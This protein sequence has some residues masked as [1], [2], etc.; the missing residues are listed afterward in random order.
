MHSC[1]V[2]PSRQMV[3]TAACRP[4]SVSGLRRFSNVVPSS[5]ENASLFAR[6]HGFGDSKEVV[7]ATDNRLIDF[8]HSTLMEHEF[9]A[10]RIIV[11][12][13]MQPGPTIFVD[14][15][16][17]FVKGANAGANKYE[18]L[19]N[20]NKSMLLST[21]EKQTR[22]LSALLSSGLESGLLGTEFWDYIATS[23]NRPRNTPNTPNSSMRSKRRRET[24]VNATSSQSAASL[25]VVRERSLGRNLKQRQVL[26]ALSNV[27]RHEGEPIF[28]S[29]PVTAEQLD[30]VGHARICGLGPYMD[31][32]SDE[33]A[34][35]PLIEMSSV[36]K[37]RG[38]KM[39]K[40]KLRKRRRK[41]KMKA[42]SSIGAPKKKKSWE[43]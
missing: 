5:L 34:L 30:N 29:G 43:K 39:R 22:E 28:N 24:V 2:A 27:M 36:L 41:L 7:R 21:E 18:A 15:Q 16:K 40:H 19:K 4:F 12:G 31:G 17:D 20:N 14:Q 6:M 8:G 1:L 13:A 38:K 10:S 25:V 9:P 32:N 37:K 35:L 33:S 26:A 3:L 11:S 42:K 23:T